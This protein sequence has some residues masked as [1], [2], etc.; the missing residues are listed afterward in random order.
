MEAFALAKSYAQHSAG[1]NTGGWPSC[2]QLH[3]QESEG[4]CAG[5]VWI[6]SS[7]QRARTAETPASSV[8]ALVTV[9]RPF[10]NNVA[11]FTS[12][13]ANFVSSA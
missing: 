8:S 10:P 11:R 5:R 7:G 3:S 9:G 12:M 1:R 6:A 4:A 13:G 2:G